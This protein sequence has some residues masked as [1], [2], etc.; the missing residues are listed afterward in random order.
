MNTELRKHIARFVVN[1]AEASLSYAEAQQHIGNVVE[2]YARD[3]TVSELL[4]ET[5]NHFNGALQQ[6]KTAPIWKNN[7]PWE[8]SAM[9]HLHSTLE[10]LGYIPD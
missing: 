2:M 8:D 10:E 6:L 9:F 3:N 1:V 5:M 7:L 4:N